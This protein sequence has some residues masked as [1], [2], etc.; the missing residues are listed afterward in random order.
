MRDDMR[1]E[2]EVYIKDEVQSFV[3][4]EIEVSH[5]LLSKCLP[6]RIYTLKPVVNEH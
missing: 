1:T 5:I 3:K 4:D 2:F 6:I